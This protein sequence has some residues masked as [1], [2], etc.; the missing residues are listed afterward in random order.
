MKA[1]EEM[2]LMLARWTREEGVASPKDDD[3]DDRKTNDKLSA[4]SDSDDGELERKTPVH[5]SVELLVQSEGEADENKKDV[6]GGREGEGKIG[7]EE[8]AHEETNSRGDD[9][10]PPLPGEKT[11]PEDA[12]DEDVI[13]IATEAEAALTP[14]VGRETDEE[15]VEVVE[16]EE[17]AV[18]P[19]VT[20]EDEEAENH[21]KRLRTLLKSY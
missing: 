14:A 10:L 19:A 2:R 1:Q 12:K 8:D 13:E 5:G 6:D 17:G 16:T 4:I 7:D 9:A 20:E 15:C 21:L 11:R 18:A 3:H